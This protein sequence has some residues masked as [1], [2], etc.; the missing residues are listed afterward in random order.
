MREEKLNS[1]ESSYRQ[2]AV[3]RPLGG[4]LGRYINTHANLVLPAANEYALNRA[5]IAIVAAPGDRNVRL[6]DKT[7]VRRIEIDPAKR[8]APT[9]TPGVRS[10]GPD[11]PR[12]AG[13]R[14]GPQ[15]PAGIPSREPERT[16]AA[17]RQVGKV[18][19]NAPPQPQYISDRRIDACCPRIELEV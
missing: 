17:R 16:Q 11:E 8:A 14:H 5:H 7:I 2:I 6:A 4:R 15:V 18:L 9:R 1:G 10:I 13:R 3:E 12:L 19:T